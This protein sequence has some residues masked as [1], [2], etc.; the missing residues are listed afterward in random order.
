[1]TEKILE[2]ATTSPGPITFTADSKFDTLV[3]SVA[4]AATV[5]MAQ[6]DDSPCPALERPLAFVKSA[7]ALDD[8][9]W[10]PGI[11]M[12]STG[13]A[14]A[15]PGPVASRPPPPRQQRS[16]QSVSSMIAAM[17]YAERGHTSLTTLV[18]VREP[19][20]HYPNGA[21]VGPNAAPS[22]SVT[23]QTVVDDDQDLPELDSGD[24]PSESQQ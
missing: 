10:V 1:M 18:G 19:F 11:V 7:V 12:A 22:G 16:D 6:V 9:T 14:S 3:M 2:L 5:A 15:S 24:E 13:P 8:T 23:I 4:P 20:G 21:G 17:E